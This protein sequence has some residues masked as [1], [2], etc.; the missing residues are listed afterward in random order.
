MYP[1]NFLRCETVVLLDLWWGKRN[2]ARARAQKRLER[3]V[4]NEVRS[5]GV[6]QKSRK[7]ERSRGIEKKRVRVCEKILCVDGARDFFTCTKLAFFFASTRVMLSC[8]A[9]CL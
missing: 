6:Q 2:T 7:R 5:A 9:Q 1:C 4:G 3:A 8:T